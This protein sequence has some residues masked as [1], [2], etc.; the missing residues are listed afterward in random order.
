MRAAVV[1]AIALIGVAAPP[2]DAATLCPQAWSRK[3]EALVQRWLGEPAARSNEIIA[4]SAGIDPQMAL[5]PP[6]PRGTL[7]VIRPRER[8]EQ[9]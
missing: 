6:G 1:A 4:P 2:A 7:R 3:A 5:T 9:Q 8:S